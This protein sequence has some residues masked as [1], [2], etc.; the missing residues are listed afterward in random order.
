MAEASLAQKFFAAV[1]R[2]DLPGI[3]RLIDEGADVNQ[4]RGG[5]SALMLAAG[6]GFGE[7]VTALIDKGADVALED[8]DGRDAK[9][10]A[11]D[12][13]HANIVFLI[14]RTATARDVRL[15]A[16]KSDADFR[17]N[18]EGIVNTVNGGVSSSVS[19]GRPLRLKGAPGG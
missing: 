3:S 5:S 4:M 1:G 14:T 18:V 17:A 10:F 8:G 15:A 19:V 16:E 7:A 13:G 2:N 12:A 9:C 6:S 11:A